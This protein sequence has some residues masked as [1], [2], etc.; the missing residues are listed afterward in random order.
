M[1][2]LAITVERVNKVHTHPTTTGLEIVQVLGRSVVVESG[3]YRVGYCGIYFP[4]GICIPQDVAEDI[5]VDHC[6]KVAVYPG[7]E[8]PTLCLVG[9]FLV[10]GEQSEGFILGP[11]ES[12]ENIGLDLTNIY[13]GLPMK[14][15]GY[16]S[17]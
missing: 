16:D 3:K 5:E 2:K 11:V 6:L 10:A 8:S 17:T 14:R 15:K 7:E 12:P 1:S 9:T 13:R 4:P